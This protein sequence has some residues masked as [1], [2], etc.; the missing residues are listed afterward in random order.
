MIESCRRKGWCISAFLA[1]GVI[2]TAASAFASPI[3]LTG[4]YVEVGISDFGTF[5]SDGNTEPGILHD[6]TGNQNFGVNDYL[7]PGS[8]HDG[9]S[10]NS[11]ETGFISNDNEGTASFGSAS[12]TIATVSGYSLAATWT[13]SIYGGGGTQIGSITNTYFF[14][15]GDERVHVATSITA[16]SR[17][18]NLYFGRSE[19]PDPDVN[20]DSDYSTVNTRGDSSTSAANLVSGAG[21]VTGL[22]IGIL[23]NSSRYASNTEIS[24]GSGVG[25]CSNDDPAKVFAGTGSNTGGPGPNYPDTNIGDYGLQMAWNI[26]TLN[27]GDTATIDYA[28]VLGTAQGS[29][30]LPSV[31][32]PASLPM[33]GGALLMLG[34]T[35][36]GA[37]RRK[38]RSAAS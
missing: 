9:F 22:T 33:F 17:L 2:G 4:N 25:C 24:D 20:T 12:P 35:A 21:Q 11:A 32:L 34:V 16:T 19:D 38:T 27:A 1:A 8:P 30:S 28:Y 26:G 29:V 23:N 5:G 10:I 36:Y 18:T 7:T 37:K 15:A 31:P 13:G 3:S 6:P 14:N